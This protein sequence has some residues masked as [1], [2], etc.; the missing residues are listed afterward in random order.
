MAVCWMA[1]SGTEEDDCNVIPT[2]GLPY[3]D[4]PAAA[5]AAAAAV[6]A[7]AAGCN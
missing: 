4:D 7:A 5:A 2:D 6:A 3:D 1:D